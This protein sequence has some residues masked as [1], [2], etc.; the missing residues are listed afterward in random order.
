MSL[1]WIIPAVVILAL[2]GIFYYL[3]RPSD[4]IQRQE[5][6]SLVDKGSF[7][8]TVTATGEL[9]AKRSVKVRGPQGMRSAGIY[10]T[11]IAELIPEGTV[12]K[13]GD[14]VATLDRTELANKLSNLQTE[15]DQALTQLEQAKI[16]TAIELRGLRDEIINMEFAR[17]EKLLNLEQS[18]YEPQSV[19]QQAQLDLERSDRDYKQLKTKYELKQQQNEAKVQEINVLLRQKQ[20]QF[21]ILSKMSDEFR[22][23]APEDGMIIY[24]RT[25]NGKKEPGSEI[26]AWDPVVAELP[27][28]TDMISTTYVNEVDVSRV[29]EGQDVTVQVDAFPDNQ[30]SGTVLR[31]A[32]IGEQLRGYDAKVFE[33]IVQV[34]EV[35]SVMRPA[36]TTSNEIVTDVLQ[37]VVSVPLE[38]LQTDSLAYVFKRQNGKAVRQE[39]ITG[40]TNDDAIVVEFGLHEGDEIFLTVPTDAAKL[41]FIPIP[42]EIK[43]QIRQKQEEEARQRKAEAMRRKEK[44]KGADMPS[45]RSDRGGG[46]FIVID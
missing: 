30:Y 18:K 10:R 12:V 17:K 44:V 27:D 7:T 35:D 13:A 38:A 8:I 21:N 40:L 3:L 4:K 36:M 5:I 19:I 9:N 15:I 32:N 24:A 33:V 31:V 41:D 37:D 22:I 39:V 23:V 34:H 43:E 26:S 20:L 16:D 6:T 42:E 2:G 1:K 29:K 46:R 45:S 14:Y 11:T 28:L 25:W